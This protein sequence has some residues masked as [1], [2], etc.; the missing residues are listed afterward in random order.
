M[1][2]KNKPRPKYLD[3]PD[4]LRDLLTLTHAQLCAKWGVSRTSAYNHQR[5][6][7]KEIRWRI[8]EVES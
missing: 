8:A 2:L 6:G 4:Y 5:L 1:T 3:K 7:G